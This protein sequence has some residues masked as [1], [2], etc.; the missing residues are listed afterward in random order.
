[1]R[2]CAIAE[3]T[4]VPAVAICSTGFMLQGRVIGK[5]LGIPHVPIAEYPGTIPTDSIETVNQKAAEAV[6]PAV[7]EGLRGNG[8]A[9]ETVAAAPEPRPR[10]IVFSGGLDELQDFFGERLWTDGLPIIPP[11]V[12]RVERFL[13][14]TPRGADDVL[15]TLPPELRQATVWSVAVNG[16]MAGCRPEY[17]PILVAIVEGIA[18]KRFRVQDG[19]STPGWEPMA[20]VSGPMVKRLGFNTTSGLMRVGPRAN[21]SIGRFL[22]LYMRN[23]SGLRVPPGRTDKGSIGAG[24]YVA[25]AEDDEALEKIG[26]EPM[27]VERGFAHEDDVVTVQSVYSTSQPIY[28]SGDH[29][30]THLASLAYVYSGAVDPWFF[31]GIWFQAWHPLLLLNPTVAGVIAADGLSKDDVRRYLYENTSTSAKWM[32]I[33]PPHVG[34]ADFRL[35]KMIESGLAGPEFSRSDDPDRTVPAML[36]PEWTNIVVA[37][38]PGR[39]QSRFYINN[40]EQGAPVSRKVDWG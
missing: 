21:T 10:D 1:M 25:L 30:D 40:H 34:A 29:A 19:G 22:R 3:K 16:V 27:R 32:E 23:V 20:I 24:L 8:A 15:G 6:A 37:G 38:D 4:G 5:S 28:S 12:G 2:A 7:I 33:Y 36:G 17:M 11:T 31:T 39:N 18:D 14:H 35:S 9:R 26:W 13:A